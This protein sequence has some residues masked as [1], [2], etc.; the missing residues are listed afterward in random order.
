MKRIEDRIINK[1]AKDVYEI[2]RKYGV[3][4]KLQLL[5]LSTFTVSTLTRILEELV[6][7][8]WIEEVGFG[9]STGGRRPILYQAAADRGYAFGFDISRTHTKLVLC[10]LH[11]N[12]LATMTWP[13]T[14]SSTPETVMNQLVHGI[15][16]MVHRHQLSHE[17]ILG[18]GI[19][20]VGPVDRHRG[21][22]L[23]PLY[24]PAEGW[25][26]ISIVE[27]LEQRLDLP[28]LLDNGANTAILAE[29][30]CD[31]TV[32]KDHML[33]VHVGTGL[34]SSVLSEGQVIY[35]SADMEG[36]VGQMIIQS[37]GIAPRDPKGN[38]G[39]LESYVSIYAIEQQAR[40]KLKQ[41]RDSILKKWVE[42]PEQVQFTHIVRALQ[43]GDSF[44]EELMTQAGIYFAIGLANLINILHPQK[45]VLGGPLISGVG[46]FYDTAVKAVIEKI[47][48]YPEYQVQFSRG[49]L[50]EEA[51]ATGA[52]IMV[53]NQLSRTQI[54]HA[55]DEA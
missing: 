9:D 6:Q 54:N 27:Q 42:T 35:G 31:Q 47:Y 7:D 55:K 13:M 41:G 49:I 39:C 37:D 19:G 23:N 30:W 16:H 24:F 14:P 25:K 20:A 1:K 43:Q 26:N 28:V 12:R 21:M 48:D 8:G 17:N 45:V 50:G 40:S 53:M 3:V 33:Y 51:L 46:L 22:I 44:A 52:A 2:L 11:Y 4:S 32:R 34:R 5:E 38:Y 15:N 36:A 18:V 10:D 29:Y